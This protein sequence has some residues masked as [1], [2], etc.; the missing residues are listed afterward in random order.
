[1][2]K[3]DVIGTGQNFEPLEDYDINFIPDLKLSFETPKDTLIGTINFE[4]SS[5]NNNDQIQTSIEAKFPYFYIKDKKLYTKYSGVKMF[6]N[7]TSI[8]V[9]IIVKTPDGEE[10]PV[11]H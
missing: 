2:L 3:D 1:M 8:D 5:L 7:L 4:P 9:D 6:R 10:F 11:K